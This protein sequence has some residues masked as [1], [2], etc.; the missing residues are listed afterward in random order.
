MLVIFSRT[1]IVNFNSPSLKQS[2]E[3]IKKLTQR[4]SPDISVMLYHDR[5]ESDFIEMFQPI[6]WRFE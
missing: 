5:A 6:K 1:I 2:Y 3:M 4:P